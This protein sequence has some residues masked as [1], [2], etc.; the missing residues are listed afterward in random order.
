MLGANRMTRDRG[1]ACHCDHSTDT[2]AFVWVEAIPCE[3]VRECWVSDAP[4]YHPV[5]R[6]KSQRNHTFRPCRDGEVAPQCRD[7]RCTTVAYE[8]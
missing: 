6:P 2:C 3:D 5:P 8:C 1:P 4:P 7:G